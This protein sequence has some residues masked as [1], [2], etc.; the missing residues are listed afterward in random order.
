MNAKGLLTGTGTK[1]IEAAY[2]S[3]LLQYIWVLQLSNH[4]HGA[5]VIFL[6]LPFIMQLFLP[7]M[8]KYIDSSHLLSM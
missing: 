8:A 1:F 7:T 4:S 6:K 2:N 3:V 5:N